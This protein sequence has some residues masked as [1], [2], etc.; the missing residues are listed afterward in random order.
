MT[1]EELQEDQY[2]TK[3]EIDLIDDKKVEPV[4]KV[5]LNQ[6]HSATN[7]GSRGPD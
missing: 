7:S 1:D 5:P 4:I 2:L 6:P 3:G